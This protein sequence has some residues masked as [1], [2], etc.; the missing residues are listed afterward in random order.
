MYGFSGCNDRPFPTH[1]SLQ[2]MAALCISALRSV[3]PAGPYHLGGFSAGGWIAYE[4]AQ[5]LLAQGERV[6]MLMVFDSGNYCRLPP[7]M[8]AVMVLDPW[9]NAE[10]ASLYATVA[11]RHL[12][13]ALQLSPGR[14]L[15]YLRQRLW[16]FGQKQGLAPL[17]RTPPRLADNVSVSEKWKY[18]RPM[19]ARYRVER[20][21]GPIDFVMAVESS[22]LLPWMW[23]RLARGGVRVNRV[24]YRHQDLFLPIA[25]T[26]MLEL[27][28][29]ALQ[30][31]ACSCKRCQPRMAPF[32]FEKC[33]TS[34][35]ATSGH[36]P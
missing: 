16:S 25:A 18:H 5:Q 10:L 27:V 1:S 19:Y 36:W 11:R 30:R 9:G 26:R 33:S 3:Q 14:A 34:T 29:Q 13:A 15:S 24:P 32:Y 2:E 20:Y 21:P 23:E 17:D 6:D 22:W 12:R 8:A 4:V 7:L 35:T 28:R 31:A